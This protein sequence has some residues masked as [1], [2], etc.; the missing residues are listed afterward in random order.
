MGPRRPVIPFILVACS[1]VA[2]TARAQQAGGPPL[3]LAAA[4]Q[5][6]L[7]KNPD[8]AT[9]RLARTASA[10]GIA[11]AE[12]WLNPE[13]AYEASRETPKQSVTG[14][15]PIELGH[16]RQYR[17]DLAKAVAA[18]GEA[19]Y[20]QVL[21]VVRAEVR[22]TYFESVAADRRLAFA[23]DLRDLAVRVGDAARARFQAGQ[24]PEIEV[25][26]TDLALSAV[27]NEVTAARGEVTA[28]RA[29]LNALIGQAPDTPLTLVDDLS[30]GEVPPAATA[31]AQA[32]QSNAELAV[33]DRR[34][35]EQQ[36]RR[37]VANSLRTP[38][39]SVGPALTWDAQPEFSV[40]WRLNFAVTLPVFATHK[41]GVIA[42][43]AEMA[44]LSAERAATA[45]RVTGS[46]SAA[47]ARATAAHEQL[48]RYQTETLPRIEALERMAQVSYTSGQTDMV[49]LL[50]QLQ[51]KPAAWTPDRHRLPD[52]AGGTREGDRIAGEIRLR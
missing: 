22:R 42:E 18:T 36:F 29:E 51:R 43:D 33:L 6:A 47:L 7:E 11:V 8:I 1:F 30:T 4:L 34:L 24:V 3:T 49:A 41:A 12:E 28:T 14:T 15:Y 44:R 19:S 50:Q 26:Q 45:A 31:V 46:V 38:D 35:V 48:Q 17:I 21:A 16:K 40:G 39:V 37:A 23:Q 32:L 52:R 20:T 10:A 27:D 25:V 5:Q 9:A 13:I 2:V